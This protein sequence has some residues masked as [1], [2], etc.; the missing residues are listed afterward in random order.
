MSAYS[1]LRITR[2]KSKAF[3]LSKVIGNISDDILTKFM[4]EYLESLLYNCLIVEDDDF[5]DDD[6]I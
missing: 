3:I 1:T 2:S 4:N 5:N 6:K